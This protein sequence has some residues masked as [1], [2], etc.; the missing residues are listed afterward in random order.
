[1]ISVIADKPRLPG[2]VEPRQRCF[3]EKPTLG[4][5]I[6]PARTRSEDKWS[7]AGAY[8]PDCAC[9]ADEGSFAVPMLEADAG[10]RLFY[11]DHGPA[12]GI[13]VL[14]LPAG[15][16]AAHDPTAPALF[17]GLGC[18]VIQLDPRGCGQSTAADDLVANTTQDTLADIERLRIATGVDRWMILG[19]LWGAALAIA[20]AQAHPEHCLG[21]VLASVYLGED[22]EVDWFFG[23]AGPLVPESWT[24]FLDMLPPVERADPLRACV[25]RLNGPD[26][27]AA[28]ATARALM[29]Y[30]LALVAY[31]PG[32][33]P[34][35]QPDDAYCLRFTRVFTHYLANNFF[36]GTGALLGRIETIRHLPARIVQGRFDIA[37]AVRPAFRLASA[38]PEAPL[39]IVDDGCGYRHPPMRAAVRTAIE[40]CLNRSHPCAS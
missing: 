35:P 16:G 32:G 30:D 33:V 5:I 1:M 20:Y 14:I 12:D 3:C 19:H 21:L 26:A 18:R 25:L 37:S 27:R 40:Q 23:G 15:P 36:L 29:H 34:L 8:C 10:H 7:L 6:R 9:R 2:D 13:P 17:T 24:G 28:T 22:D 38:W 39:T 31:R 4:K 11:R